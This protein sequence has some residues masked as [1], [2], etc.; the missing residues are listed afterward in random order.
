MI[1]AIVSVI[2][3]SVLVYGIIRIIKINKEE[4]KENRELGCI[5]YYG[6]NNYNDY[7]N[8]CEVK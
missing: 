7:K 2:A 1:G 5:Y 3:C 6:L 4:K 8:K